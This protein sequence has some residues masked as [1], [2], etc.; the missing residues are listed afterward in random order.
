MATSARRRKAEP[1]VKP[2]AA[3]DE[4]EPMTVLELNAEIERLTV[5]RDSMIQGARDEFI[6]RIRTEAQGLGLSLEDLM[7]KAPVKAVKATKPGKSPVPGKAQVSVKFRD[8]DRTWT[9]RGR[10]PTWLSQM[11]AE[12]RKRDEFLVDKGLLA[13]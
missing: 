13:A 5:L 6:E 11:E 4:Q 8:G 9:G 2:E 7:P 1:G 3:Q 10:L 12:G